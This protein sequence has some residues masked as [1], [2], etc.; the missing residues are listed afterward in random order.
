MAYSQLQIKDLQMWYQKKL[1]IYTIISLIRP[2]DGEGIK[3]EE[4]ELE[5]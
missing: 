1:P 5:L 2:K 4:A 3:T